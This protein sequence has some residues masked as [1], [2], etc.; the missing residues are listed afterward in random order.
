MADLGVLDGVPLGLLDLDG[1][2]ARDGQVARTG[3][4]VA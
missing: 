3:Y 2:H 1:R 4:E